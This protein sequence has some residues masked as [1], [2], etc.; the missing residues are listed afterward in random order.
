[1]HDDALD[2]KPAGAD[3]ATIFENDWLIQ[4]RRILFMT[5]TSW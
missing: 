5:L 1:M 2:P 4:R 3:F